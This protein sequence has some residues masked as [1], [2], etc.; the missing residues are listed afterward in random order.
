M[1]HSE[2]IMNDCVDSFYFDISATSSHRPFMRHAQDHA[3]MSSTLSSLAST[4]LLRPRLV[5][6]PKAADDGRG[7]VG[8]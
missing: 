3:E 8:Q 4:M 7:R 2:Q 1:N 6:A 5:L